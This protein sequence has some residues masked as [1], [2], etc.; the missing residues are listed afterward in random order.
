MYSDLEYLKEGNGPFTK[1]G[2]VL[3]FDNDTV[4]SKE[5][6]SR[7]YIEVRYAK[8]IMLVDEEHCLGEI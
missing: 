6:N 2:A 8:K 4:E 5:K 1:P 7:L 3:K